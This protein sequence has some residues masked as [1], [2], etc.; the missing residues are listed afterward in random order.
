MT[1]NSNPFPESDEKAYLRRYHLLKSLDPLRQQKGRD[2]AYFG[3]PSAEMLDVKLWQKVLGHITA[4]EADKTIAS[5]IFRTATKLGIREKLCLLETDLLSASKILAEDENKLEIIFSEFSKASQEKFRKIR[6]RFYDVFNLDLCG[7]F[8]YPKDNDRNDHSEVLKNLLKHQRKQKEDFLIVITFNLRDTGADEYDKFI[9][10]CLSSLEQ[11]GEDIS[12]LKS[13]YLSK[14][15]K[16]HPKQLRRIR[17]A[18]PAYIQKIAFDDFQVS[19][20]GSW[21]YKTFYNTVLHFSPRLGGTLGMN[22]PPLDEFKSILNSPI[23]K[24]ATE[25]NDIKVQRLETPTL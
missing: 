4:V 17:F 3:L 15:T 22:W 10:H 2:L 16:N 20:K 11:I 21:Y 19:Q 8:L 24:V 5:R 9:D 1:L 7:G 12:S 13:Y 14:N 18:L 6:G 25:S 23:F